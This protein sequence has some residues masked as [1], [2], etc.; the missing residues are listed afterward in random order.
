VIFV[1]KCLKENA[2]FERSEKLII[3][4]NFYKKH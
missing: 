3:F 4:A 1:F 2:C